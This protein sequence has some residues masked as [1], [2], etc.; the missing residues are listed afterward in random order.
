MLSSTDRASTFHNC[1]PQRRRDA[2]SMARTLPDQRTVI[3]AKQINEIA[4]RR[5]YSQ[6]KLA[7]AAGVLPQQ[8]SA[9]LHGRS[10]I[11]NEKLQAAAAEVGAVLALLEPNETKPAFLG[12]VGAGGR[13]MLHGTDKA[14]PAYVEVDEACGEWQAGDEVLIVEGPFAIGEQVLMKGPNGLLFAECIERHGEPRLRSLVG[15][16]FDY[17]PA[18]HTIIGQV[19]SFRRRRRRPAH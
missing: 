19:D 13:V 4:L 5:G 9:L 18:L 16:T 15:E 7:A 14:L 6:S 3:L 11:S 17:E 10:G 2:A 1:A 12:S 8:W